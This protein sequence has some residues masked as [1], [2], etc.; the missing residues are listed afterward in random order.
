MPPDHIILTADELAQVESGV[1]VTHGDRTNIWSVA[2]AWSVEFVAPVRWTALEGQHIELL[3]RTGGAPGSCYLVAT[4]TIE[5]IKPANN[6][7][8]TIHLTNIELTP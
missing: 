8:Y 7:Q 1:I 3:R 6:N 5:R 4:C 2:D